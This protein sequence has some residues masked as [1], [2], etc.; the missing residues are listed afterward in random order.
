MA[1][2]SPQSLTGV[3]RIPRLFVWVLFRG[4]KVTIGCVLIGL[5]LT[6]ISFGTLTFLKQRGVIP[7]QL[8]A[9]LLG[10]GNLVPVGAGLVS[11]IL[12][13]KEWRRDRNLLLERS[14][15]V[16]HVL[17]ISLIVSLELKAGAFLNV[18]TIPVF[19]LGF[20]MFGLP[21]LFVI[22][23]TALASGVRRGTQVVPGGKAKKWLAKL[24]KNDLAN[25]KKAGFHDDPGIAFWCDSRIPFSRENQ[26]ILVAGSPGSG[27]TQIIYPIIEQV[28]ARGDKVVIWD[29]KGTYTQTFFGRPRVSL[30]A[31]W[32]RRS[33][34]WRLGADI[35]K[36]EDCH[37]A[38]AVMI[39][40]NQ[41][42]TQPYFT[43]AARDL[44]EA[45]LVHLDALGTPWGWSDVYQLIQGGPAELHKALSW[46]AFG[47]S[48]AQ[49]YFNAKSGTD[50]YA[51][52]RSSTSM[53]HWLA[54]AWPNDGVSLR[55]WI[56]EGESQ[57]LILGG[58]PERERLASSTANL[59]LH[60]MVKQLLSLPDD[61]NRRVWFFLDE[62]AALGKVDVIS[63][64]GTMGRSK[65]G[66]L[67]AGIQDLGKME[68]IY[69]RELIKS[70][71]NVFSTM[72][73]LRC[74]DAA[75]SAWASEVIGDQE[76]IDLQ[77][78]HSEGTSQ[79]H[80]TSSSSHGL[81]M[82]S[83]SGSSESYSTQQVIRQKRAFLASQITG[84]GDLEGLFRHSNWP[85][86]WLGWPRWNIPQQAALVEEAAWVNDKEKLDT[87]APLPELPPV[88]D[89]QDRDWGH[90]Q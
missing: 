6:W 51:T 75:T 70:L 22:P 76:V 41:K 40:Q 25:A 79:S 50:V 89:P 72:I 8:Y 33:I 36:P 59:A 80:G 48:I 34:H 26:H 44:L 77:H 57:V 78:S 68:H 24:L 16:F 84:L 74:T 49:T 18:Q 71:A 20:C 90:L 87:P 64:L 23:R 4:I 9:F 32:D 10:L 56:K 42:E 86:A 62:I 37:Q 61:L 67:V 14:M 45:I 15:I 30:L 60:V 1:I 5:F 53:V 21:A 13:I 63:D 29:V 27:K 85:V 81:S 7:A 88:Q 2:M 69:G 31:P 52:L 54:K 82:S 46:T 17:A 58:T 43:N 3:F 47:R 11:W 66:C 19:F 83:N 39:P 73:F 38:A 65:G 12:F 28:I 35:S 55:E